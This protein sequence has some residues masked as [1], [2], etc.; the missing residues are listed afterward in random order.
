VNWQKSFHWS[1]K[2]EFHEMCLVTP[3]AGALAELNNTAKAQLPHSSQIAYRA[4]YKLKPHI[5]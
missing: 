4:P 2:F 1:F 5:L 3:L